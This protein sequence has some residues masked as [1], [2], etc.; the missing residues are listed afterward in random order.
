MCAA[1]QAPKQSWTAL[2]VTPGGQY[3]HPLTCMETGRE[4]RNGLLYVPSATAQIILY[5]LCA[6]VRD[7]V[8]E[9]G[10]VSNI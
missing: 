3:I 7:Y 9:V 5:T 4:E 10:V 6:M 1:C 8:V 2:H